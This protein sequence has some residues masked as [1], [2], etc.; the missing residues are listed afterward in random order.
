MQVELERQV[1]F[2]DGIESFRSHAH[3]VLSAETV[4]RTLQSAHAARPDLWQV[5]SSLITHHLALDHLGEAEILANGMCERFPLLPRS[6]LDRAKVANA[7]GRPAAEQAALEQALQISPSN[8]E[9][10][11]ELAALGS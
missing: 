10:K 7:R 11:K 9:A 4:Q 8:A 1:T 2:G 3:G 6:W 5:W